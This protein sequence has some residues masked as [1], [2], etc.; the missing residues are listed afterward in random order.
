MCLMVVVAGLIPI[1]FVWVGNRLTASSQFSH[2][3]IDTHPEYHTAE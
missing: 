2:L 1:Q 3:D